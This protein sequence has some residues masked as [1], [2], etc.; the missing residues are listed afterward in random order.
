MDVTTTTKTILGVLLAAASLSAQDANLTFT[1]TA[2]ISS[3]AKKA[4]L[5]VTVHIDRFIADADRDKL[6]VALLAHDQSALK[7]QLA[8]L[9][10]LGSITVV[11]KQTPIKYAYARPTA[12]GRL[13]TVVTAQP[14]YFLGGGE[15]NAKPKA[16]YDLAL[17]LLVLDGSDSG[18]GELDPAVKVKLENGA[19]VTDGYGSEKVRLVKVVK[20]GKVQ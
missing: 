2:T 12:T 17:A 14:V 20:V 4:S 18:D 6:K 16:G 5:P 7:K 1:A 15:K 19:I 11:E 3:P 9:P 8:S 10:D 13:I